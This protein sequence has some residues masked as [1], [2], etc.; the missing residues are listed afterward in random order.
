MITE[1]PKRIALGKRKQ[2]TAET[3][4]GLR[5]RRREQ[6]IGFAFV[7]PAVVTFVMFMAIPMF[8]TFVISLFDWSGISLNSLHFTGFDN[9]TK[10]F[11]D[12]VFWKALRNNL[13]FLALG[14]TASVVLG[15]FVAVLL[16]R[17]LP[18]SAFF[19]GIFFLPTVLSTVVIGI[20]F[21][22]LLSP[23][24]GILKPIFATVGIHFNI[25]LLGDPHTALFTI[26]GVETWRSFGFAMFL[27]V[28]GLKSLDHSLNEV[29]QLDGASSW[30]IFWSI[31]LPQLRPVTLLV[32][33]LVG[34]QTLK[35]F[36]LVYVMTGGGPSNAS[37]VFTT[38][39]YNQAFNYNNVGYGSAIAVMLLL[40][41]F[42]FTLL[43]FK[44][45][46]DSADDRGRGKA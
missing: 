26:I 1:T 46:P 35:L 3:A 45:L 10:M 43:R 38:Y 25:G 22:F 39:S 6:A 33:T 37:D 36:D 4:E 9:Y 30:Q 27:F 18:G 21:T 29:A 24:F 23:V 8:L 40:L 32:A 42:G 5:L 20:V 16:E 13:I 41:T 17:N 34:I 19:R 14:M 12:P 44:V 7:A 31:T 11:H 15:L 28:A 2:A